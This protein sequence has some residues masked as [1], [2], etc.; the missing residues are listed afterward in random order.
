MSKTIFVGDVDEYYCDAVK[1]AHYRWAVWISSVDQEKRLTEEKL[2][3][4]FLTY[5]EAIG[6][7]VVYCMKHPDVKW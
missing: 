4:R 7:V 1:D 5:E 3:E 6:F 2:L